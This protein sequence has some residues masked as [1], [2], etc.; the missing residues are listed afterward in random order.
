MNITKLTV[1]CHRGKDGGGGGEEIIR[2]FDTMVLLCDDALTPNNQ[3]PAERRIE[4]A[5]RCMVSACKSPRFTGFTQDCHKR[6][7]C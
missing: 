6:G 3:F 2:R 5:I 4:K 1:S 7:G